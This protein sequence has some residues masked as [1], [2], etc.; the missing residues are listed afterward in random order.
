MTTRSLLGLAGAGVGFYFGGARGAQWGYM[1]G[2][3]AGGI[4]DPE[5][6]RGPSLGDGQTQLAQDGVP[7]PIVYGAMVVSGT[8]IDPGKLTK[9]IVKESA[10]KGGPVTE[11][12]TETWRRT[13]AILIAQSAKDTPSEIVGVRRVWEDEKLVYDISDAAE[14][15][16]LTGVNWLDYVKERNSVSAQFRKQARFYTGS[17]TQNPDPALE[18]IH[19]VGQTPAYRGRAYMVIENR[20]LTARGGSIPSYRFEVVT[21][22]SFSTVTN[23]LPNTS[24][25]SALTNS[26]GTNGVKDRADVF[27][28]S[29][30]AAILFRVRDFVLNGVGR[31]RIVPLYSTPTAYNGP[32]RT[33]DNALA[34]GA[35]LDTGWHASSSL[36][37]QEFAQFE[38]DA[39]R[40]PPA[41]VVG[42]PAPTMLRTPRK[43]AGL[44][45]LSN[46]YHSGNGEIT[47]TTDWPQLSGGISVALDDG[48]S[49]ALIASDGT[50]YWPAWSTPAPTERI[51]T[52]MVPLDAVIEDIG[53][54][55][56]IA[57]GKFDLT[58]ISGYTLR[59]YALQ[60]QMAAADA[61]RGLQRP[62]VFDMPEFDGKLRAVRRG[63]GIVAT[64]TDA[65]LI[66]NGEETEQ[67]E[68]EVELPRVLRV[69]SADPS[70]N[71]AVTPQTSPR[72][73]SDIKAVG[74]VAVELALAL[75]PDEAARIAEILHKIAWTG[76]EGK[77][78]LPL[79]VRW[80]HLVP[81]DP[82]EYR[83]RRYRIED[84][85]LRDGVYQVRALLDRAA[86]S[87]STATG[88]SKPT[89]PAWLAPVG[90]TYLELMNLPVLASTDDE[91]GLYV[92]A[93]GS[94]RRWGGAL[95]QLSTDNGVSWTDITTVTQAA[96]I[97]Y[98]TTAL[99]AEAAATP[100]V[101]TLTVW[102]P[103]APESLT[104]E[105]ML[106]YG[107]RALL[108]DEIIQFQT[109][110]DL[111]GNLYQLT[112]LVRGMY[113]TASGA[114][115]ANARFVL[116]GEGV[117]FIEVPRALLGQLL[118][119][120]A[121]TSG[122]TAD[123]A[124]VYPLLLDTF[125]SQTEFPVSQVTATRA[126][127][128]GDVTVSWVGRGRLGTE[129]APYHSRHWT[130]Y[131]VSFSDGYT[132]DTT[133]STVTYAAAPAGITVT[134]AALNAI[135]GA[136]PASTGITV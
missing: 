125:R 116:L 28:V 103:E 83:S 56:G 13:Y 86:D 91:P 82:I 54:M 12:E 57:P 39:G 63:G 110:T 35:I 111:G 79:P 135:T 32:A 115:A 96:A 52:A 76:A 131:R 53:S 101:Q 6:T 43:V 27:A 121:V 51:T 11:T 120:R 129:T 99:V 23:S 58:A 24:R 80:T 104:F 102:L 75:M 70:A 81:S 136:G 22:G 25:T 17:E 71:Y 34:G 118:Q 109:A 26:G 44:L 31:V 119:V 113:A 134:V 84:A 10:G 65:D 55:V 127:G 78:N 42:T 59:G 132:V 105:T 88:V 33:Q 100:S 3:L 46:L 107:N 38:M 8:V 72:R 95:L 7:M 122:G 130:G 45:V 69:F 50:I 36:V 62:Y 108:G 21:A 61:W 49:D 73:V 37:A 85:E 20:D 67:R 66:D 18:A 94:S 90:T 47:A 29:S 126:A 60:R 124:P 89:A 133:A 87:T 48:L 5:V 123:A 98:S 112:G 74:E 2:S 97:G 14:R 128:S 15:P 106:R 92:A 4:I 64:I 16:E 40:F 117:A 41:I 1:L 19:G 77:I 9:V 30:D 68:Q 114:Q 93:Y